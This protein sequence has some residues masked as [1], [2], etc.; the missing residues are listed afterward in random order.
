[1][2]FLTVKKKK[3]IQYSLLVQFEKKP[4]L[5]PSD[6]AARQLRITLCTRLYQVYDIDKLNR[7]INALVINAIN[8]LQPWSHYTRERGERLLRF[9]F[10]T[11]KIRA[12]LI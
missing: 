5:Y 8:A 9:G 11:K 4:K 3:N 6:L 2:F 7:T 10:I 1:M 12:P